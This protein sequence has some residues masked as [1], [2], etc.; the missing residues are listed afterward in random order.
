M[1]VYRHFLYVLVLSINVVS[2]KCDK[3]LRSVY[4][5]ICFRFVENDTVDGNNRHVKRVMSILN[6]S[7]QKSK[8]IYKSDLENILLDIKKEG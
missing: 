5:S 8:R 1:V 6:L 3:N 7:V 4:V 2:Y